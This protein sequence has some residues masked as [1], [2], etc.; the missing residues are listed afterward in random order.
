MTVR[1]QAPPESY[2]FIAEDGHKYRLSLVSGVRAVLTEEG[3]GMP[4][5]EYITERAPYQHGE[6]IKDYFLRPRIVQYLYRQKYCSREAYWDG[7]NSLLDAL[8]PNRGV[9]GVLRTIRPQG[10]K[11]DLTVTILEG[12]KFE[13]RSLNKWDEWAI[14]EVLRFIAHDPVYFDPT[15]QT[16]TFGPCGSAVGFPYTFPFPFGTN[17]CQLIFPIT[18]PITFEPF[19][20]PDTLTNAGTWETFPTITI[21]GPSLNVRIYNDTTGQVLELIG[22]NSPVGDTVTFDLTFATKTITNTAGENLVQYLSDDSDLSTFSLVP[23]ENDI[24]VLIG[25]HS[26]VTFATFSWYNRYLGI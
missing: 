9:Q 26:T 23:G 11:R 22:Y 25:S 16:E 14:Q 20:I 7:R 19:A 12:P 4:P 1:T 13:A 2:M 21:T 3:T 15:L 10:V 17:E 18:F 8:R 24:R 6:S 5:I